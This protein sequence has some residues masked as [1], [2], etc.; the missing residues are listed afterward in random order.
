MILKSLIEELIEVPRYAKET[1]IKPKEGEIL[2]SIVKRFNFKNTLEIGLAYGRSASYIISASKSKHIVI[3]PFQKE[4]YENMGIF[5]L[6]KF[7]MEIF[8]E[9]R[10]DYSH[11]VLPELLKE[12][13]KFDFIFIDGDHKYDSI[14]NDFYYSDLLLSTGGIIV[15][16]DT[17][18]KSTQLVTSFISKN[19]ENYHSLKLPGDYNMSFFKKYFFDERPWDHFNEFYV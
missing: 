16:H 6:E 18:M 4:K 2:H 13:K 5:N 14:M 17:W 7:G 9:F 12:G 11:I 8:L 15:F 1:P 19:R 3:D 10:N